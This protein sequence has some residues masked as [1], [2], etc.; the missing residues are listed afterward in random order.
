MGIAGVAFH[1]YG[2]SRSMGGWRNWRQNAFNGPPLPAPPSF[3]GLAL[4]GLAA[5]GLLRGSSRMTDPSAPRYPGYD[6]LDKRHTPSWD[7]KPAGSSI[8]A[9]RCRGSRV[10]SPPPSGRPPMRSVSGSFRS[11]RIV[12]R[13]RWRRC[14]TPSC[15]PTRATAFAKATCPTCA[16]PGARG[17]AA[18]EAESAARHGG[19]RFPA[20]DT[21]EQDALL[22]M[23]HRGELSDPA[24]D[25]LGAKNFFTKRILSDIPGLYYSHPTAWSEIGLGGPASPRG[26]VRIELG[27]RDPWE[28]AEA[29]RRRGARIAGEQACRLTRSRRRGPKT[30]ARRTCSPRR[31]GADARVP[32]QDEVDFAIVG[33]GAGGGTLAALLAEQGFSVVA[34]DAGPYFR[35]LEEFASDEAEQN[36]LYWT[37]ERVTDGANP[38]HMGGKNS[39]KAVGGS[40][41]HYAMVSL[42]FRPE[43][44][45]SRT[46]TRL[47]RGLADPWEEMWH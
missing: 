4:A 8:I 36:K 27:R 31:L 1:A 46:Q 2:V 22:G 19:R 43:W 17:L 14:S 38:I 40:T 9:L 42:R 34:F 45:K 47:R 44:F 5:L 20:L 25:G 11:R 24:W 37:D 16:K 35:P 15:S 13:C 18:I 41:V 23:M 21:A 26:Y 28:A 29:A 33:T 6:V 10:S 12:H 7:A 30:A 3:S 32:R 39:G